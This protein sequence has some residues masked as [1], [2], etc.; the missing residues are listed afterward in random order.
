MCN[1]TGNRALKAK[2]HLSSPH[3]HDTHNAILYAE[4]QLVSEVWSADQHHSD[5]GTPDDVQLN[6]GLGLQTLGGQIR[7]GL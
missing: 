6:L 4:A 3:C 2:G 1:T 5:G 7:G